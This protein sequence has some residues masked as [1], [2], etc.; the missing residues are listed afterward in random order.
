MDTY[1]DTS[2]IEINQLGI[3]SISPVIY[4]F[5]S[6]DNLV[7][8]QI[9]NHVGVWNA[10]CPTISMTTA[11][12]LLIV[13]AASP[14]LNISLILKYKYKLSHFIMVLLQLAFC[15]RN[16]SPQVLISCSG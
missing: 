2:G 7:S 1:S 3:P 16:V 15:I 9:G 6:S 14:S 12:S 13:M 5:V 8:F 10:T 4:L 11:C